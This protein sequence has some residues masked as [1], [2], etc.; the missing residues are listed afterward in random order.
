MEETV[1]ALLRL[2]L[3]PSVNE[4]FQRDLTATIIDAIILP[5]VDGRSH[6]VRVGEFAINV[7]PEPSAAPVSEVLDRIV[8][9]LGYLRCCLPTLILDLLSDSF[10]PKLSSDLI[11]GWLSSAIP[12][13][14]SGLGEFEKTLNHV[15]Q[16]TQTLESLGWHGEEELVSWVQQAPR[17]WLTRRRIHSL[18]QVRNVLAAKGGITRQV[19]KVETE[20]VTQADQTL[21]H[22][23]FDEWHAQWDNNKEEVTLREKYNIT[24]IPDAVLAIVRQQIADA[25]A[26]S[27]PTYVVWPFLFHTLANLAQIFHV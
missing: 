26:L 6:G 22:T 24:D 18:D 25:E 8:E 16:F 12:T 9:V 15:L 19:E 11:S 14:L 5:G 1:A 27:Q 23:T 13:D 7:D 17:L 21:L 4:K 2:E 20:N 10:V 3:F